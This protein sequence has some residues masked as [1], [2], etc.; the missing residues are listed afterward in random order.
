MCVF[1]EVLLLRVFFL[2]SMFCFPCAGSNINCTDRTICN[3]VS[4]DVVLLEYGT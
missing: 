3:I 1:P 2:V 4:G